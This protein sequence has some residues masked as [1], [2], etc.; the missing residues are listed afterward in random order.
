MAQDYMDKIANPILKGTYSMKD[1]QNSPLSF[2]DK[3]HVGQ[4]M[5][6]WAN[7]DAKVDPRAA[8][9]L[10]QDIYDHKVTNTDQLFERAKA[11][12]LPFPVVEKA[13]KLIDMT[14]EGQRL[15]YDRKRIF[16][17]M[18]SPGGGILFKDSTGQD[19]PIGQANA[20]NAHDA[21][22]DL[23]QQYR[24]QGRSVNELYD[25]KNP[26]LQNVFQKYGAT[27]SQ[28]NGA[29]ARGTV[30]AAL[31][32]K[33]PPPGQITLS[34]SPTGQVPT[35]TP[36]KNPSNPL[37]RRPGETPQQTLDRIKALRKK[38]NG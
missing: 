29:T 10:T 6:T 19:S 37:V 34:T 4:M 21:V 32:I 23:E 26:D 35:P 16:D 3:M 11:A 8:N 24:Q 20:K 1:L 18:Q 28:M 14:P 13:R 12:N 15:N 7:K 33:T 17:M 9:Q 27:K 30:G 38:P 2:Q 5:D 36:D 25:T 22:L 31:G